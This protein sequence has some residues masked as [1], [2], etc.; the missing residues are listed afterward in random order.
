MRLQWIGPS[1]A[2]L[3]SRPTK[4][5]AAL[6]IGAAVRADFVR[7]NAYIAAV[8]DRSVIE[9]RTHET[10]QLCEQLG[11][12][13]RILADIDVRHAS[14]LGTDRSV[15]DRLADLVDR[16]LADGA[17]VSGTTTGEAVEADTLERAVAA[18]ADH[19]PPTPIFVGSGVTVNFAA[20]LLTATDGTIVGTSLKES[21]RTRNPVDVDRVERLT[22][23]VVEDTD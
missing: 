17:I 6:S 9:G 14:L 15:G 2:H 18:R 11:V 5:E 20:R 19:G 13:S 21:G 16:G 22:N 12:D 3:Q 8:T 10:L 23:T 1:T 7:I 4:P